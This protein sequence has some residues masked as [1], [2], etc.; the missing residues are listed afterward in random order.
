[1]CSY[2]LPHT[3]IIYFSV[4][5]SNEFPTSRLFQVILNNYLLCR[6]HLIIFKWLIIWLGTGWRLSHVIVDIDYLLIFIYLAQPSNLY[7][8]WLTKLAQNCPS[9]LELSI[10]GRRLNEVT[11]YQYLGLKID[12]PLMFEES[13]RELIKKVKNRLFC[14]SKIWHS[15]SHGIATLVYKAFLCLT[16]PPLY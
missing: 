15:W 2:L 8:L 16:M 3:Y 6:M 4:K 10:Q 11:V 12:G 7:V 5:E 14:L 9:P 1:M 13:S